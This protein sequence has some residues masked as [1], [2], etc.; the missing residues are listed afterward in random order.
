MEE[1]ACAEYI[2]DRFLSKRK[3]K[4]RFVRTHFTV[5]TDV[6]NIKRVFESIK[7]VIRE[8]SLVKAGLRPAEE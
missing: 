7:D 6:D 8:D 5:A 2:R 3:E 4:K 1:K